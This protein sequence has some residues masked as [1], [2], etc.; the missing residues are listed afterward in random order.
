MAMLLQSAYAIVNLVFV[1]R[2][3]PQPVAGLAI[4]FQAFFIILAISQSIATS[5]LADVSQ[6]FGAG[7]V[8]SARRAFSGYSVIGAIVGVASAIIAYLTAPHY[9][10]F[11]T[12]DQEVYRLG[13]S[14]FEINALSFFLQVQLILYGNGLRGSGDFDLPMKLMGL[15]VG[16]NLILDP[17]L[18]FGI[19]PF[20]RLGLTG[21]AWATVIA[22]SLT[23][24]IYARVLLRPRGELEIAWCRPELS[25]RLVASVLSRGLPAGMQFFLISAVMGI[26]LYGVKSHGASWTASAGG[27]FRV[28]QQTFLP[29]VALASAA[30][31]I[32]GQN[33]G[34]R[35]PGRVREVVRRALRWGVIY[36]ATIGLLL[37]VGA[38][39]AARIFAA[40]A[41][42]VDTAAVYF[43]WSAP[44]TVAFALT[45]VPTFVLQAAGQAIWPLLA[46]IIRVVGLALIVLLLVPAYSLPPEWI[47][48]AQTITS[49]IEGA[50]DLGLVLSF[51]RRIQREPLARP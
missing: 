16:M 25:R 14:Y 40:N 15:S 29:M 47:F 7:R 2:L 51:V 20:P 34:A 37:F 28:L 4:S 30:A 1:S 42:E 9:V 12:D 33:F 5:T 13:L 3:G 24:V 44:T 39:I 41:A 17:F 27:G 8:N 11:F 6:A 22:Q 48:G 18:I 23:L 36:S 50:I 38:R 43:Y 45:Y 35:L 32:T 49:W 26:V 19:G 21:A 31:A 46:A 10:R